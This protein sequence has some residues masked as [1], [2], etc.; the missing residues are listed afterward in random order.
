MKTFS[1]IAIDFLHENGY[2][3]LECNTDEEAILK[4]ED[5][6]NGSKKYPV[7]FSCSDTTG[8]K[9]YEEFFTDE[10]QTDMQQF[11]SL[12]VVTNRSARPIKDIQ[13]LFDKLY[14]IPRL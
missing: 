3:I 7:H 4:A 14:S 1:S 2:E 6:K 13:N 8:E 10:E 11:E 9:A 12:G 5:L